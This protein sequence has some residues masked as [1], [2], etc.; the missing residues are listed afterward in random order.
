MLATRTAAPLVRMPCAD[1]ACD[2]DSDCADSPIAEFVPADDAATDFNGNLI[3]RTNP[4]GETVIRTYD[5]ANR[6]TEVTDA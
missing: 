3:E 1:F 5:L 2:A 4:A 6:L